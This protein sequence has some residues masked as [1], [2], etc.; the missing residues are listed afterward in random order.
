MPFGILT[1]LLEGEKDVG[2]KTGEIQTSVELTA[3]YQ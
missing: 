1:W 3:K 2:G